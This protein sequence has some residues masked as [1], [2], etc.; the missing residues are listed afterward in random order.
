MYWP[1]LSTLLLDLCNLAKIQKLSRRSLPKLMTLNSGES[2]APLARFAT[3][4]HGFVPHLN[5]MSNSGTTKSTTPLLM[6]ELVRKSQIHLSLSQMTTHGRTPSFTCF[7][8]QYNKR[9]R[10]ETLSK[11]SIADGMVSLLEIVAL[12]NL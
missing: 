3:L 1:C 10:L 2:V 6:R 8:E 7:E 5:D 12:A 4:S 9:I 11:K